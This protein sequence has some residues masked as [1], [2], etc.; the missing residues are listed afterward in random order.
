MTQL[1]TT[2]SVKSQQEFEA[3]MAERMRQAM[4]DLMPD[5]VLRGIVARGI[6]EAFFKDRT[7]E[8]SY[9]R[10]TV[11]PAWAVA[12]IRKELESQ[13]AAQ[14]SCWLVDNQERVEKMVRQM[15]DE[16]LVK[17]VLGS[18]G[19]I[20]QAPFANLQQQIFDLI[21]KLRAGERV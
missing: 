12:F 13:V 9:G 21:N 8:E 14:V 6:E 15:V 18:L 19:S 4:G 7:I 10:K 17:A 5:E 2:G 16:G 11:E 1:T 3:K 20:L